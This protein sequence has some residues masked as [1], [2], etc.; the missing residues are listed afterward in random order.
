ML[1]LGRLPFAHL[2]AGLIKVWSSGIRVGKEPHKASLL[3][4]FMWME[5]SE[6]DLDIKSN[7]QIQLHSAYPV[8][9]LE[10]NICI[11][12]ILDPSRDS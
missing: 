4:S 1:K 10:L 5:W 2:F 8:S 7:C 6:K 3:I 12:F 9:K 11:L